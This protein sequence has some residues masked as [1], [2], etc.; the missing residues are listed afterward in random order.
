[1]VDDVRPLQR[2]RPIGF[3]MTSEPAARLPKPVRPTGRLARAGWGL[4]RPAPAPPEIP[5]CALDAPPANLVLDAYSRA[6]VEKFALL[7]RMSDEFGLRYDIVPAPPN[8]PGDR[9]E[10]GI[11]FDQPPGGRTRL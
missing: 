2:N 4:R 8:R 6:P 5:D 10:A 1:M 7:K 11:L 9:R 3:Y